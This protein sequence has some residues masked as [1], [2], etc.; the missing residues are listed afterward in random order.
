MRRFSLLAVAALLSA[1]ALA[2]CSVINDLR[3]AIS[4]TMRSHTRPW[5]PVACTIHN[6]GPC[7]CRA[8]CHSKVASETP[9]MAW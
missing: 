9:W 3:G 2:G 8:A 7:P 5:K 6:V 4:P 1:T